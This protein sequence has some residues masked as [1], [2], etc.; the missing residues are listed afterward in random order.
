M[1]RD[2]VSYIDQGT[3]HGTFDSRVGLVLQSEPITNVGGC[4]HS[5]GCSL[6]SKLANRPVHLLHVV[7]PPRFMVVKQGD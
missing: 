7:A 6:T 3:N 1:Y 2:L 5:G 4:I